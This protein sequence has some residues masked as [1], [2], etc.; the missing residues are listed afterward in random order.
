MNKESMKNMIILRNLP[1]NLVEE[2]IVIFKP[3]V[4]IKNLNILEKEPKKNEKNDMYNTKNYIINEAQMVIS[5]YLSS[6]EKQK[7]KTYNSNR[8]LESKYKKIKIICTC[9]VI[10]LILSIIIR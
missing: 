1:S 5:N 7:K 6:I 4:K 10:A 8:R 3:N 2:A 9:L